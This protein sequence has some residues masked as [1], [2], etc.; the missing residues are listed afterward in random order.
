M[1]TKSDPEQQFIKLKM[2]LIRNNSLQKIRFWKE[3]IKRNLKEKKYL[4]NFT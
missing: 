2:K 4:N 3:N 1:Q